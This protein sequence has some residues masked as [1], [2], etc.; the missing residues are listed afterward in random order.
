MAPF[1]PALQ[2][3]SSDQ[4]FL[5]AGAAAALPSLRREAFATLRAAD[6]LKSVSR[7]FFPHEVVLHDSSNQLNFNHCCAS[8][9]DVS[10]NQIAYGADV[11]VRIEDL[12]RSHFVLVIAL[13]GAATVEFNQRR[14][15]LESGDC[16][17]MSPDIRYN[18]ELGS[19]HTHLA[20]GIPHRR[21]SDGGRP[22]E[23]VHNIFEHG[24]R[25]RPSG[26]ADLIAFIEYLCH[27]LHRASPI[28]GLPA[29]AAANENCFLQMLRAAFFEE[30][31][32][33]GP[34]TVLPGF[35]RRAD[36]FISEHLKDDI[37]LDDIVA[38]AGVP[39]R[40]LYHGFERF[41]GE[42][43]MRWLRLRRLASA[44]AELVANSQASV[45]DVVN[46]YWMGHAGRFAHMYRTLYG[47]TPSQTRARAPA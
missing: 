19:D 7:V 11:D 28:F 40:T 34:S 29:V 35:V 23:A 14:W 25:S 8:L 31:G 39:P 15:H 47:E 17:L 24:E 30:D 1:G 6:A 32:P 20:I 9:G 36:R 26:V 45:T 2:R 22:Y 37:T 21:L 44:R 13:S 41:L 3:M 42:S 10:L 4:R 33:R 5:A 27:E 43:P 18:F 16:V 38:A 12:R 46:Q